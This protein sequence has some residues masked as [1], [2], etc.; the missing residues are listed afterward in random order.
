M[1][2]NSN[3]NIF[4]IG[5]HPIGGHNPC[6]II[7]EIGANHDGDIDKAISLVEMAARAGAHAIK[8]QTYTAS[9]LTVNIDRLITWGPKG[10]EK[11]ETIGDMFDRLALP[12]DKHE[13]VFNHAHQ[14]GIEA[15]STP[16]SVDGVEFLENLHVP[17]FKIASSDVNFRDLLT[18]TAQSQKPVILS[19]GKAEMS[20]ISRAVEHLTN[21]GLQK[22]AIL[23]CIAQYPAPIDEMRLQTI[24]AL[25]KMWP[26]AVIGF[27]DHSQG[28][29]AALG[30]VSLGA[31]IIEKHIT[32]DKSANGPD[33]WFSADET[34]LT[35]LC[36]EIK[37]L[38]K[39]LIGVRNGIL[40]CELDER[41][42]SV[43]SLV[44]TRN[45]SIGDII[46]ATD[47]RAARPG[48]G[49]DPFFQDMIIGRKLSKA[50]NKDTVLTWDLLNN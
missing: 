40:N 17:A 35:E 13:L 19:T 4:H 39:A 33:H 22:L 6:F 42:T 44:T 46:Q 7:A 29:T 21:N 50:I 24:P 45:L 37:R 10:K 28:I 23:H 3:K 14:L 18:A 36:R 12:R 26:N 20:E 9:E 32:Y 2:N 34:E 30:A 38:E 1:P 49:I 47:I 25:Q 48:T 41:K 43:R 31:K 15:F 16:F 27:S 11:Q 8:L 5:N